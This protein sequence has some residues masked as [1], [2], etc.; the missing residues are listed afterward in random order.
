MSIPGQLLYHFWYRPT[1]ALR[2][3]LRHGG[4]IAQWHT[5]RGRREMQDT[6]ENL[7]ALPVL[8]PAAGR[9]IHFLTGARF[10]WQTAFCLHSLARTSGVALETHLYDDGTLGA[11]HRENLRRLGLPLVFHDHAALR[12]KI[13]R[14]LPVKSYPTLRE[15]WINYPHIRKLIDVHLGGTGW[16]LVLDS[17]LL[18]YRRPDFLLHWLAAPDRPLHAVDCIESYGYSRPLLERLAG[19][20]LATKL[21]VGLCGLN[22]S[23]IDWDQ[24]EF[25]SATMIHE[26]RTNYYLEQALVALLC[27]GRTCAVA[28]ERNYVTLPAPAEIASP[29]AVMHHYVDTAKSGYFRH[30]WR[31]FT[32]PC[33]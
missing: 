32:L 9:Q 5:E 2:E 16:K 13:E 33:A 26:E 19:H 22:S 25:W 31:N 18:F 1:G 21:N 3:S 28:P 15:R 20:P 27:A 8:A 24:L 14:L 29:S 23:E 11:E 30:A 12:E 7:P 6:A 4:P 17:D 10:W